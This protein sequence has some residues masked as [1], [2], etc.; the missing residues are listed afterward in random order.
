[1]TRVPFVGNSLRRAES[2]Y[3]EHEN[4]EWWDELYDYIYTQMDA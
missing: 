3:T 4:N 2:A 1:M